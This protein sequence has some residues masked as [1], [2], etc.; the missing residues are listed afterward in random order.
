MTRILLLKS[1]RDLRRTL[2]QS[3]ALILISLLGVSSFVALIGAFRDLGTSYNHAYD[4]L[5]FAD[6]E[7][8]LNSAPQ[9]VLDKVSQVSGV[10]A[11]T[12]RLIIDAG[13]PTPQ[14]GSNSSGG[15]VRARLIGI[16]ADQHPSVNDVLVEQGSYLQPSNQASTLLESH[17]AD[18]YDLKPGDT[19]SPI[20]DGKTVPLKIAGV[21]A[22]P[23]YLIVSASRQDAIPSARSFAV[24]FMPLTEVQ[25]V[26]NMSGQINDLAIRFAPGANQSAALN[27]VQQILAPY[28]VIS[29]TL[30]ADQP[31]NAALRLDLNGYREI[32]FLMPG[33]ILLVGAASLYV[34]LGRQIRAQQSQIGLMKALGYTTRSVE[35]HYLATA[36]GIALIGALLGIALG[37]PLEHALT[38]A[39]ASEL[40][41]PL[42]KSRLY[43]D[44]FGIGILLSLIA[45]LLGALGPTRQ[46]A[47]LEPASAMR[48][49]PATG[50]TATG[51]F[52]ERVQGLPVWARMSL[53]NVLRGR[54]RSLT[55]G[56][57]II[58]AFTLVLV[59]WSFIDS[60][61]YVTNRHF[62]TVERWDETVLFR[63]LQPGTTQTTIANI[64]GVRAVEPFIQTPSTLSAGGR[65]QDIQLNAIPTNGNLHSLQLPS[66]INPSTAL[67]SGQIVLTKA[68]AS[69]LHVSTGDTV[70]V[71]NQYGSHQLHVSAT[72]DELLSSV[73]YI[74]VDDARSW[75]GAS[76][77]PI[78]AAY[79]TVDPAKQSQVQ[80]A[81]YNLPGVASV[82]LKSA[83]K[84][85]WTSLMGLF[86]ALMGTILAFA[87]IMAFALLFN[88]MTV[89][90]LER[91]RE[92][93]TMRA[94]GT[95]SG[96]IALL[97]STESVVL[98][99]LAAIPGLLV[100]YWAA[101]QMGKAF[102]SDL[103]SFSI[104]VQP[105]TLVV[106][107][108]GILI[109]ML[110]AAVP[111]MR[112][113]NHLN[114]AES[115][116]V[117]S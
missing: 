58:F 74:S 66:G 3:L 84:S 13:M 71:V 49:S 19:V 1:F 105:L 115:T 41:I 83:E 17:F 64:D 37:I 55:T 107:A 68:S 6:V 92:F 5:K 93:A 44:I 99:I 11:V 98:W 101:L 96:M 81:L 40:G 78:N 10:Q 33:L 32:A 61:N 2:A 18:I 29:T 48:P 36:V 62:N 95:G 100:G 7:I 85:D 63:S 67:A 104:V 102:Q 76:N 106:T 50:G 24:L 57:G 56:L 35:L 111:A 12:G 79:V 4:Q 94:V 28:G 15:V 108:A 51:E 46:V 42:V 88:T 113:V 14:T 70:T 16:P 116:K 20:V 43:L 21:V 59:G 25:Q 45:A 91:E 69:D 117:L 75:T 65:Q 53:R 82:Q 97:L 80:S 54:R 26:A 27:Q 90:V 39:Y 52:L 60:M 23:E 77:Q 112:R 114:L 22:S 87:V 30:R 72:V 47:K 38:S 8:S 86:Y 103:F 34:M 109:T 9:G 89:N 110:L 73:A 31:S